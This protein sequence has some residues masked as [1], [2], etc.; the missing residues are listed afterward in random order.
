MRDYARFARSGTMPQVLRVAPR[1]CSAVRAVGGQLDGM[2][3]HV[4]GVPRGAISKSM[5][6]AV[7]QSMGRR[8]S[9]D[10]TKR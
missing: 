2:M 5:Q 9:A 7:I 10:R 4:E 1:V 3:R 6:I 8:S